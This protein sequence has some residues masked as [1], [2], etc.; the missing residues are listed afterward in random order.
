MSAEERRELVLTAATRAFA[1]SGYA[2]TSTDAVAREAG[3]SQPYVVRIF[4]TKLDLFLEVFE[5]AATRIRTAFEAVL[6]ET[7]FDPGSDEDWA[8]MGLAYSE[9]VN[10]RD[11]LQVMMHGFSAG[12]V[13]EIAAAARR[14]MGDVFATIKRTG[15]DDD[16][17]R[18]FVAHGMLLNVMLSMRAPEHLHPGEPLTT[19]AA[20]AF[21][22][23]LQLLSTPA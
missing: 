6:D 19:L 5:R 22:D 16:R 9:L 11:L 20:C 12:G 7:P 17:A 15:C 13:D 21:G 2:G 23:S 4:G 3:V 18:D 10:D 1:R 8:R 14:C